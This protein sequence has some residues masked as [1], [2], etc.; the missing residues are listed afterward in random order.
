MCQRYYAKHCATGSPQQAVALGFQMAA[1]TTSQMI[2]YPKVTM[3]ASPT[4]GFAALKTSD[5]TSWEG[6]VSSISGAQ[7]SPNVCQIYVIHGSGGASFRPLL[8]H[9]TSASSYLDMS[10][11]L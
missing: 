5:Y 6:A 7:A 10:A 9:G 1:L 3:R 11:E 4:I 2:T 8:L